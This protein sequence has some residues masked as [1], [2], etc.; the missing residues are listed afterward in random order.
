MKIFLLLVLLLLP[1]LTFAAPSISSISGT[2]THGQS[3]TINGSGFGMKAIPSPI[4]YDDFSNAVIGQRV[5]EATSGWWT[6]A[7]SSNNAMTITANNPRNLGNK[8]VNALIASNAV[9]NGTPYPYA[10]NQ[11]MWRND[12]GF[13]TTKKFYLNYW[14]YYDPGQ[15]PV[16]FQDS[17]VS[18]SWQ[19][20]STRLLADATNGQVVPYP[21]LF[22]DSYA[23][24]ETGNSYAS[25]YVDVRWYNAEVPYGTANYL[26]IEDRDTPG[27]Y[28]I[29]MYGKMDSALGAGD[30]TYTIVQSRPNLSAAIQS[31]TLNNVGLI[32]AANDQG[33]SYYN[34]VLFD[35]YMAT[36][37]YFPPV[38]DINKIG[39]YPLGY[40]VMYDGSSYKCIQANNPAVLPADT[41]Y[42]ESTP[43]AY[44]ITT[45]L[46]YDDI[47]IDNSW[48]R[49]EIGDQPT[50]SACTHR[51]IQIPQAIWNDGQLQIN[52]NQG[53]FADNS[54]AYLYVV[55]E[56]GEVNISGY[57][58]TLGAG[59]DITAPSAPSGLIVR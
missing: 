26:P 30:A 46:Q 33:G 4:R 31:R 24:R 12:I 52:V 1:G 2:F 11:Q 50:Y 21:G 36:P 39:G 8:S 35:N 18:P 16:G 5:D 29:S 32:N 42:W 40:E 25:N 43:Y 6:T 48:A 49:V 9:G 54:T 56:N 47:Y 55:D 14:W 19:I 45:N 58:V 41:N 15:T 27:W 28:Q 34:A 23:R 7:A 22:V 59:T 51:E 10:I 44:Q 17:G 57:P 13:A 37:N 20:K 3:L 38:F 53:S